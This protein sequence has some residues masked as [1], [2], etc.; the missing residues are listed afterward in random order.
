MRDKLNN[1]MNFAKRELVK[2]TITTTFWLTGGKAVG[3][4]IP[5]FIAALFGVTS[6]TDAFFFVYGVIIFFSGIFASV[7]TSVIVPYIA[8]INS[9]KEDVGKFVGNILSVSGVSVAV[10]SVLFVLALR[11][12]VPLV[13]RFDAASL[14]LINSLLI[15]ISPLILFIVWT[16]ILAGALN[17]YKKF[18][19]SAISPAIRGVVCLGMIFALKGKFGVYAV[20]WGYVVG[21]I[22]RFFFLITM[23]RR[24]DIFKLKL[25]LRFNPKLLEFLKTASYQVVGMVAVGF[26]PVV[27]RIMASWL[28]KGSVSVL[29]YANMLYTI[30]T[31]IIASGLTVVVLSHWSSRFYDSGSKRLKKDMGKAIKTVV[32]ITFMISIVL[33]LFNRPIVDTALS[34]GAFDRTKLPEV[35]LVWGCYLMGLIPCMMLLLYARG[36]L[37][38]KNTKVLM[39]SACYMNVLNILLNFILMRYF[40]LAGIAFATSFVSLACM[41]YLRKNF[42]IALKNVNNLE[43]ERTSG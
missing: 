17:A 20:A 5:F 34:H 14:N 25:C 4:L 15:A 1:I 28:E 41:L 32:F 27:D 22:V 16:S 11:L 26:N 23:I 9:K 36:L 33:I 12:I 24:L 6:K 2:D 3:F 29:S 10:L 40:Q 43:M 35:S 13:T 21:E 37:V 38:M 31:T 18:A 39:K 8:E 30:P 7:A 42:Y 19:F